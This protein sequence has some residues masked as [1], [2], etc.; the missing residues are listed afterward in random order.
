M[1]DPRVT[2]CGTE[3]QNP[4][5]TASG[6]F[7]NSSEYAQFFDI[8]K[9]GGITTKT[10]TLDPKLGNPTP[11]IC[12]TSSGLLNSI[13]LQNPGVEKFLDSNRP[14]LYGLSSHTHPIISIGGNSIQ[15]YVTLVSRLA[16]EFDFIEVNISCPNVKA[17]MAFGQDSVHA[18]ALIGDI[19]RSA[20]PAKIIVKLTP[21]VTDIVSIAKAVEDAGADAISLINT[22]AGMRIDPTTGEFLIANK[23]GGLSGPA[24]FPIAIRNIYEVAQAVKIPIIGMGG[25]SSGAD[26]VEMMRAG[27]SLVAIGTANFFDVDNQAPLKILTEFTEFCAQIGITNAS[28]LIGR[29]SHRLI[30]S[31]R[32]ST[33]DDHRY[34]PNWFD[35]HV[36]LRSPEA[37]WCDEAFKLIVSTTA[38]QCKYAVVM[39]NTQPVLTVDEMLRYREQILAI[40]RDK[41]PWFTPLMTLYL[42][43]DTTEHDIRT[44]AEFDWFAGWK[45]YPQGVTTGSE[46]GVS[47]FQQ[48]ARPLKIIDE[49]SSRLLIH[50]EKPGVPDLEAEEAFVIEI[51]PMIREMFRGKICIEH[52]STSAAIQAVL[53]DDNM[54]GTITPHHLWGTHGDTPGEPHRWCKPVWQTPE[55]AASLLSAIV[56][57]DQSKFFAGTDTAPHPKSLK[58]EPGITLHGCFS[59]PT[60]LI[61]YLSALA[62]SGE[63]I[64]DNHIERFLFANAAVFYD[65]TCSDDI[66]RVTSEIP[67]NL[68]YFRLSPEPSQ[69]PP[70]ED[71]EFFNPHTDKVDGIVPVFAH[72][73]FDLTCEQ[74]TS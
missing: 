52:C 14:F 65:I 7:G 58:E 61:V 1:F 16:D 47:D 62:V 33:M 60:A 57:K 23:T 28:D 36:H 38:R 10:I 15:E 39:P 17:G 11:R 41:F 53:A 4:I 73:P 55:N 35:A 37:P 21:N 27:A 32:E 74:I 71:F 44:A 5:V 13:G 70:L 48:L 26:V 25:V 46:S 2:F 72:R 67:S 56:T 31:R 30:T 64:F 68:P 59:A 43:P 51:L 69:P 3:F 40:T 20:G 42:T 6:T 50:G 24:I 19:K 34:F 63:E 12:R 8:R 54:F 9:L 66:F 29:T 18:S 49:V 45:L 22:V